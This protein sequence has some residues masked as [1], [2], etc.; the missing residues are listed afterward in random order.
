MLHGEAVAI[1]MA[2]AAQRSEELGLAPRGTAARLRE[3]LARCA[4]PTALP[5][6]SRSAYLAALRVDKKR[7]NGRIRYVVLRGIGRAETVPLTP[8]EI[9]PADALGAPGRA[10]KRKAAR[11]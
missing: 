5:P 8:A 1:G 2:W 4:L 9:L 6:F 10:R 11:D 7:K 3:L